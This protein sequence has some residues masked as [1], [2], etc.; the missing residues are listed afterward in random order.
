MTRLSVTIDDGL[1]KEA[2]E[3]SGA[4]TKREAIE[5]ALT[6]YV[7]HLRFGKRQPVSAT[8]FGRK[9]ACTS[10]CPTCS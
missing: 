1:L 7:S 9:G 2:R 10:R 3:L 5:R 8:G 6:E 4:K